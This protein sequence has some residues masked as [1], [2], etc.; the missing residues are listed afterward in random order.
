MIAS[1]RE[2][3]LVVIRVLPREWSLMILMMSLS[4][5]EDMNIRSGGTH[6]LARGTASAGDEELG[7]GPVRTRSDPGR[8]PCSA[9][10]GIIRLHELV[11][12]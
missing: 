10:W 3:E 11:D 1:F 4:F 12:P 5:V 2:A 7:T 6:R 9:P 8:S